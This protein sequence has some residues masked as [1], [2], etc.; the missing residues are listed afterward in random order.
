METL[1]AKV[2]DLQSKLDILEPKVALLEEE[3]RLLKIKKTSSNSS[4][5]PSTDIFKGKKNQSLRVKSGRKKGGQAGLNGLS[6][7]SVFA[8]NFFLGN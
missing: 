7:D 6:S 1:I 8:F 4:K 2:E 3:N 5:P